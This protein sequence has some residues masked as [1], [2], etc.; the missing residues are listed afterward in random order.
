M[1]IALLVW[2]WTTAAGAGVGDAVVLRSIRYSMEGDA[3]KLMI[4]TTGIPVVVAGGS[5]E[6]ITL[7]FR[8]ATVSS[9]PGAA[10]VFFKDGPMRSAAID[11][12]ASDSVTVTVRLRAPGRMDVGLEGHD[13]VL[14]VAPRSVKGEGTRKASVPV[15]AA[16]S[17]QLKLR[18]GEA[19]EHRGS[20]TDV[21]AKPARSLD[22]ISILGMFALAAVTSLGFAL[23][24]V[25]R[26][27]KNTPAAQPPPV[28][29]NEGDAE[30]QPEPQALELSGLESSDEEEETEDEIEARAYQLAKALRRGKGEMDLALRMEQRQEKVLAERISTSCR[31]AKTKAQRVRNAKRLGVGR[32]EI[33][34]ALRL[35]HMV[36]VTNAEEEP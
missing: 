20:G 28:V 14:Q 27:E 8:H 30:D 10:R 31:S 18:S 3:G 6:Y 13:V 17:S 32:G 26:W 35:K 15:A 7:G 24:V 5:G 1:L 23:A 4:G 33:D 34:L 12:S 21:A 19:A 16:I 29:A 25:R 22:F 9:P 2:G 36:P 11:R